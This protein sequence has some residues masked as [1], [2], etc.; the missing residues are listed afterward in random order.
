DVA[1]Q[2]TTQ[3]VVLTREVLD[4]IPNGRQYYSVGE[5]APAVITR[6][7]SGTAAGGAMGRDAQLLVVHGS[8]TNDFALLLDGFPQMIFYTAVPGVQGV[9]PP[10]G[11]NEEVN[12]LSGA[13]PAEAD[14]GGVRINMVPK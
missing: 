3:Q 6:S 10:D 12:V 1:I 7:N 2:T 9:M 11:L 14:S 8:G 5:L 13:N 4:T